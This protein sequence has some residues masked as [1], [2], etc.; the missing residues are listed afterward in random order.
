M[1]RGAEWQMGKELGA[2]KKY[3]L[4]GPLPGLPHCPGDEHPIFGVCMGA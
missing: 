4:T 3:H 1:P 2:Q